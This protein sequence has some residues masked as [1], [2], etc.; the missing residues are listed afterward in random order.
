VRR[1]KLKQIAIAVSL[2]ALAMQLI[3]AGTRNSPI[4]PSRTIYATESMPPSVRTVFESSCMNCHSN[5][6]YWPWYSYIAPVSWIV[7]RDVHDGR[8]QMNFSEWGAYS[9]QKREQKLEEICEQIMNGDM[10]DGKYTF[11]HRNSRL[12][13]EQREAVCEWTQT[14][15]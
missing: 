4:V 12:T 3:P 13:Q 1:T 2:F 15:R 10:P 5:Q 11:I 7:A 9:P 6:T 14:P 8:R